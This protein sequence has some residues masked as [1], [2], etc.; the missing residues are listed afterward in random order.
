MP[1]YKIV[2]SS[3]NVSAGDT[4]RDTDRVSSEKGIWQVYMEAGSSATIVLQGRA[5]PGA[6]WHT[7]LSWVNGDMVSETKAELVDLFPE[8]TSLISGNTGADAH[9][10]WLVE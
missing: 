9:K 1:T 10:G 6:P 8:M 3:G 5:A 2:D 4:I 7:I